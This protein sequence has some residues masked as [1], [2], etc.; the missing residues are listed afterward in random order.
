MFGEN[1]HFCSLVLRVALKGEQTMHVGHMLIH[2][3][4]GYLGL[5]QIKNLLHPP[6]Q[7][8]AYVISLKTTTIQKKKK[9]HILYEYDDIVVYVVAYGIKMCPSYK[10]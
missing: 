1:Y 9:L 4:Q 7:H 8:T 5:G 10:V 2:I 6:L 3:V